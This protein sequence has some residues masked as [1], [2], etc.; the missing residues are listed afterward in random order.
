VNEKNNNAG[1]YSFRTPNQNLDPKTS[2]AALVLYCKNLATKPTLGS[3]VGFWF[4]ICF[5]LGF[6]QKQ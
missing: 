2:F 3:F 5:F 1:F 6:V 4:Y